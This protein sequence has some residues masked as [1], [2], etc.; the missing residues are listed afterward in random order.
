MPTSKDGA[1]SRLRGDN[2]PDRRSDRPSCPSL[3]SDL[4]QKTRRERR[5]ATTVIL[6]TPGGTVNDCFVPVQ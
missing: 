3:P 6:C 5:R 1:V 2:Y 4:L